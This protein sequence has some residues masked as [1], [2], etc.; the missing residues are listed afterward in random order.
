VDSWHFQ[1][2]CEFMSLVFEINSLPRKA[3]LV[4]ARQTG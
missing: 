4:M 3:P 2:F 1:L